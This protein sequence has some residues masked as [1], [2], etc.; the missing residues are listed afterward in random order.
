[1][2]TR[3][4]LFIVS[5]LT[6]AIALS[7]CTAQPASTPEATAQPMTDITLMLDWVP[8]TNHTGFYV[9][10]ANGYYQDA[11]LNVNIIEPGEVYAE[12]AVVGG[13]VD[14]GVSF[15]EQVTLARAQN[16]TPLVS[17]AAIIQHNTSGFAARPGVTNDS[18]AD[19]E[20]LTY[21]A[22]GS[23][24][25]EPTLQSL[26]E[27]AGGDYSQLNIVDVG[28]A[29]PLAL[30]DESRIDLAWI[31]EGWQGFQAAQ[32]GI[33]LTTVPMSDYFD[34]IP[35]YYTPIL[36]ASEETIANRPEVVRAFLGAT[37]QG[38]Q[39]AIDHPDEAATILLDAVPELDE[40]TVRASQAW[41]SQQYAADAPQWGSQS[42]SVWQDYG[43]WMIDQG[44]IDHF[45]AES[46]FTAE[47]LP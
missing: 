11:G 12:Q 13:Q 9:A 30:L 27:C 39:Y 21:G 46:A 32:Q 2:N 23:P 17:I 10:Q 31:F 25:E 40:A 20:G 44:I 22:F 34:C 19:W 8:N 45:D 38:Y 15:Q 29:D 35:D 1:M 37:A 36:V 4:V 28:F 24:F 5:M 16:D 42:L 33:D 47:F 26:M 41:L 14:F 43:N 6:L 3:R 7:A 18:P